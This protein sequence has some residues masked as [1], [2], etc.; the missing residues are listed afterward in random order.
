[1]EGSSVQGAVAEGVNNSCLE[2]LGAKYIGEEVAGVRTNSHLYQ[3]PRTSDLGHGDG[4]QS[5][6]IHQVGDEDS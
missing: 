5:L 6:P 3:R 4:Y 2:E 1:M